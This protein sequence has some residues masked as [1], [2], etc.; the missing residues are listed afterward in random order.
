MTPTCKCC[1]QPLVTR[2]GVKLTAKKLEIY[3]AVK[4]AGVRGILPK[5]IGD[6]VY[7][8]EDRDRAAFRIRTHICQM[9]ES[10]AETDWRIRRDCGRYRLIREIVEAAA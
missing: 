10:L 4:A 1:G 8:R 6:I 9:N 5:A 3:D 7:P 2:H